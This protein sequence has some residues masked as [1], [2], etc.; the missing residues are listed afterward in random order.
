M[1]QAVMLGLKRPSLSP[2]PHNRSQADAHCRSNFGGGQALGLERLG[3]FRLALRGPGLPPL[4]DA[5][6]L[7]DGNPG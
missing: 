3:P 7:G 4:V 2:I 5:L 1:S 6:F